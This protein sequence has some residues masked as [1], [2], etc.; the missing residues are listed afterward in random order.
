MYLP[1]I[2]RVVLAFMY[3]GLLA[4]LGVMVF[5]RLFHLD[6]WP[7]YLA[8]GL[9][10][11]ALSVLMVAAVQWVAERAGTP[12]SERRHIEA[13]AAL[14]TA[15]EPALRRWLNRPAGQPVTDS[16]LCDLVDYRRAGLTDAIADE[17]AAAGYPPGVAAA[18]LKAGASRARVD[19]LTA[20]MVR[21]G[22]YDGYDRAALN[23]LIGWHIDIFD[24]PWAHQYPV[25]GRWLKLPLSEVER[26]AQ[27]VADGA[28]RV[29]AERPNALPFSRP[30]T[31]VE[32]VL[33]TLEEEH[34]SRHRR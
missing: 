27:V 30:A 9:A 31:M 23:R 32:Q 12:R 7:A 16:E 13:V 15:I 8:S 11:L 4:A 19:E 34:R 29:Q 3:G 18:A 21:V 6:S 17:W 33:Y 2:N 22:A 28:L 20:V 14:R 26:H 5:D 10:S 24:G 25:L 1:G